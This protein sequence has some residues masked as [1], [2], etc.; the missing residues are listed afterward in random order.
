MTTNVLA[1]NGTLTR[2]QLATEIGVK[3]ATIALYEK[4]GM[5]VIKMGKV[6]LYHWPTIQ[7]WMLRRCLHQAN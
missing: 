1:N 5:P 4:E 6:S 3:S 7:K 2:E